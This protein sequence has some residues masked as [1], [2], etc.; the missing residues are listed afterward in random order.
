MTN[1]R[2]NVW[3]GVD[4]ETRLKLFDIARASQNTDTEDELKGVYKRIERIYEKNPEVKSRLR[5]LFD[6]A[7]TA[8]LNGE[9]G[10]I[11]FVN[12]YDP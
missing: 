12:S 2:T 7:I 11:R 3:E 1:E 10:M 4:V 9:Q 8:R 6:G 5:I